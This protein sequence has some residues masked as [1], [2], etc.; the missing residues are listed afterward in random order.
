[1]TP[2]RT[3]TPAAKPSNPKRPQPWPS[4]AAGV[5]DALAVALT[6]ISSKARSMGK[7]AERIDR[8]AALGVEAVQ[9]GN[10]VLAIQLFQDIRSATA[11][12]NHT[13]AAITG[14]AGDAK[15]QLA[16]ARVGEYGEG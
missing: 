9:E 12:Q 5:A 4:K 7:Q 11:T 1:M 16:A 8:L 14:T 2:R 6:D 13:S 15:A 3:S 10:Y